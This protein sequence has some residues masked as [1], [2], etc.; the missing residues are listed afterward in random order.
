MRVGVIGGGRMG[1]GIAQVFL[2]ID[3]EV[4][5]VEAGAHAAAAAGARVLAGLAKAAE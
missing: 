4:V 2:G 5:L 1:A 3:A